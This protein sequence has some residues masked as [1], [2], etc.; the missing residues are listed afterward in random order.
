MSTIGENVLTE[1]SKKRKLSSVSLPPHKP[2]KVET[3]PELKWDPKRYK[4]GQEYNKK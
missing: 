1:V 3:K 2:K 4:K